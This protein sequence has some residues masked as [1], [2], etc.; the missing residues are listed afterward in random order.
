MGDHFRPP[1]PLRLDVIYESSLRGHSLTT[2]TRLWQFLTTYL[3]RYRARVDILMKFLYCYKE[4]SAYRWHFPYHLK[5]RQSRNVF[6]KPTILP[7]TEQTNSFFFLTIL[8]LNEFE[9]SKSPFEINWPLPTLSCQ[10][11]LWTSPIAYQLTLHNGAKFK[12]YFRIFHYE[13]N[14]KFG[15]Y[16]VICD[17]SGI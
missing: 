1:S 10:R 6:F 5:V 8:W 12:V 2:L 14:R 4:K 7:K 15:K 11:S 3:P 13:N 16:V 9:D 17:L